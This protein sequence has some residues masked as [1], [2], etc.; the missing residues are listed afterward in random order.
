LVGYNHSLQRADRWDRSI[1]LIRP[2]LN[3]QG[4][5]IPKGKNVR[6][7]GFY[8]FHQPSTEVILKKDM[9]LFDLWEV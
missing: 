8:F 4:L 1:F 9:E 6:R 2:I 7:E 3:K 5:A